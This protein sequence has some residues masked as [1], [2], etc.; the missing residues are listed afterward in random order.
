[1]KMVA[2]DPIAVG[3]CCFKDDLWVSYWLADESALEV[4][5]GKP[6]ALLTDRG[7]CTDSRVLLRVFRICICCGIQR[8]AGCSWH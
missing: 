2:V 1:M 3:S 6:P 4:V 5:L 7:G 8:A